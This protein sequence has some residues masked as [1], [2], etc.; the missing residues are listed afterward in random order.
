M[1]T[2]AGSAKGKALQAGIDAIETRLQDSDSF[3]FA[4]MVERDLMKLNTPS[5]SY[6]RNKGI[7]PIYSDGGGMIG[8]EKIK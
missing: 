4:N 7:E 8:Y 1:K 2:T 5:R 3:R 6:L